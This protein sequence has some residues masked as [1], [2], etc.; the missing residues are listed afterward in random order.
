MD[1]YFR[2]KGNL[3]GVLALIPL[4]GIICLMVSCIPHGDDTVTFPTSAD[5]IIFIQ[6]GDYE[7]DYIDLF[8]L[9]S[10]IEII[11]LET[12]DSSIFAV[13]SILL[14]VD[15]NIVIADEVSDKV[16]L[17]NN[18]GRFQ[19]LIA[20][21]GKGPGEYQH[22]SDVHYN[23][24][25]QKIEIWDNKWNFLKY[26]LMSGETTSTSY[27]SNPG[28]FAYRFFMP[29]DKASYFLYNPQYK[30]IYKGNDFR[31]VYKEHEEIKWK[32]LPFNQAD[33]KGITGAD[34][35]KYEDSVRF[36]ERY[37]PVVYTVD[38][39]GITPRYYFQNRT[40]NRLESYDL[41]RYSD[42]IEEGFAIDGVYETQD[43]L[44]TRFAFNKNRI[45]FYMIDKVNYK[46]MNSA[47]LGFSIN[48]LWVHLKTV[49]NGQVWTSVE[50]PIFIAY[51]NEI[52]NNKS[53][54]D[55][56]KAIL[57]VKATDTDNPILIKFGIDD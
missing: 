24:W 45:G 56:Q 23:E 30:N 20:R 29:I 3:H 4:Y 50:A 49:I 21:I 48:G 2:A 9:I 38:R 47:S 19:K 8:D 31:L 51:Q 35:Y 22:I 52:V 34:F 16:L 13:P 43:W 39:L 25:S 36:F 42:Y 18:N 17:F 28:F 54:S 44:F 27:R 5:S 26:N 10:D 32:L 7:N 12:T 6:G 57:N 14:Q 40:S 1:K 41:S 15:S 55:F 46:N 33:E 11:Q 53:L 37:I